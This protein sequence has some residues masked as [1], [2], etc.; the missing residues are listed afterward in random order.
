MESPAPIDAAL[1]AY[2]RGQRERCVLSPE[3][4]VALIDDLMR[5]LSTAT[6]GAVGYDAAYARVVGRKPD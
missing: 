6:D 3:R 5:S 1:D 4:L 2:E